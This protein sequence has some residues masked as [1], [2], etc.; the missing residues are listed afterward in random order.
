MSTDNTIEYTHPYAFFATVRTHKTDNPTYRYI[1]RLPKEEKLFWEEAMVTELRALCKLESSKM[2]DRPS[3]ANI[4][5]S[6][7]AF[8]KNQ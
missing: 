7:W 3:G 6:T 8:K 2:V 5:E 4:L 1:L